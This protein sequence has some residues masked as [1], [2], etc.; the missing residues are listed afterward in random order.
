MKQLRKPSQPKKKKKQVKRQS[1]KLEEIAELKK[2]IQINDELIEDIR[3]KK[4]EEELDNTL[5]RLDSTN[6]D[7]TK[8]TL[9]NE[10]IIQTNK[11]TA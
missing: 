2:I 6:E 9:E 5:N 3:I 8:L 4:L 10:K 7:N 11:Q 1:T